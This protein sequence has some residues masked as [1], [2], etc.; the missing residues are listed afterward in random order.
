[1]SPKA[2]RTT[3]TASGPEGPPTHPAEKLRDHLPNP[4]EELRRLLV[5]DRRGYGRSSA[6]VG[7]DFL[8]DAEDIAEIM[9]DGAHLVGHSYGGLAETEECAEGDTAV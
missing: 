8:R 1:M 9:D 3:A 6:P 7:E 2:S 4:R 5:L